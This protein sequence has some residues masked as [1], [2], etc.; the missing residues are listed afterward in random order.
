MPLKSYD[1]V[2]SEPRQSWT[3]SCSS[4]GCTKV[5]EAIQQLVKQRRALTV[6]TASRNNKRRKDLWSPFAYEILDVV[7][8][9]PKRE[10]FSWW[11][12]YGWNGWQWVPTY[13][14]VYQSGLS[15]F[16]NDYAYVS[17]SKPSLSSEANAIAQNKLLASLKEARSQWNFAVTLGES[18]ETARHIV[19]TA[20]R[21]AN[22][23]LA[24][25]K[26]HIV[27]SY[28][29]LMRGPVPVTYQRHLRSLNRR[30]KRG[31][32]KDD[33]SSAWMEANYAWLPLLGDIDSAAKYIAEKRV[34]GVAPVQAISR[35]H[36]MDRG[37][38]A[39]VNAGGYLN[40]VITVEESKVRYTYEVSPKYP[41]PSTLNELGFTDPWT[42]AWELLPLSF[43]VDWFVNVGQVL[44]SLHEFNQWK[45]VRGIRSERTILSVGQRVS[46]NWVR[47]NGQP[48]VPAIEYRSVGYT[49]KWMSRELLGSLPTAVPLRIKV[50]N[51]F[52]LKSGNLATAV[53]LLRY[54]F[55]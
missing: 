52:D 40:D 38:K 20:S 46:R 55:R 51:P 28:Q 47:G 39:T 45:V 37:T 14:H 18:V 21:L 30:A 54:A 31:N 27:K 41:K 19:N 29:L 24:F 15:Y 10:L 3:Q 11:T 12:G 8:D 2:R 23:F 25:K 26:G 44:E 50:S 32:W 33:V 42:L 34:K 17:P 49:K 22:A 6:T 36:E 35:K 9:I 48:V 13:Q 43:V 16:P 1:R 7:G 53:I 5:W 4:S